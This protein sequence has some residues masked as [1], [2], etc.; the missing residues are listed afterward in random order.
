MISK[1]A[2]AVGLTFGLAASGPA[3]ADDGAAVTLQVDGCESEREIRRIV[4][5]ELASGSLATAPVRA[6]VACTSSLATLRVDGG[7]GAPVTRT[8]DLSVEMPKAHGRLIALAL[9]ELIASSQSEPSTPA[10]VPS[11]AVEPTVSPPDDVVPPL[12]IP[13]RATWQILALGGGLAF[14]SGT[15]LLGGGGIRVRR[16]AS[17]LTLHVDVQ[18]HHGTAEVTL[19]RVTTDILDVAPA[20]GVQH[21]WERVRASASIGARGGAVR[22]AGSSD[23]MS[24][25]GD[26]F[27]APWFG[28]FALAGLELA[29]SSR[30]RLIVD[31]EGGLVIN[32]VGALVEQ[33]REIA[34]DGGWLGVHVGIGTIL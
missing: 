14:S 13:R 26:R 18:A 6:S 23:T 29:V 12:Q 31:V 22:L 3:R 16:A 21:A 20:V 27:W 10:P 2:I 4:D 5:I 32:P 17:R 9:V 8:L 30:V 28:A 24:V 33:R 15:G 7:T 11:G 34:V 19:G 25:R 1:A